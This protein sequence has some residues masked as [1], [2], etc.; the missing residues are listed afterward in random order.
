MCQSKHRNVLNVILLYYKS[1][2]TCFDSPESFSG[3]Q[4]SD[5]YNNVIQYVVGSP[6][7]TIIL[8]YNKRKLNEQKCNVRRVV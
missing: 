7:F 4:G 3:P 6:T 1:R 5:P 8:R 2:A